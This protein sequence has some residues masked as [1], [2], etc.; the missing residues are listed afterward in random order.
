MI[1]LCLPRRRSRWFSHLFST[2]KS[3]ISLNHIKPSIKKSPL[4]Q[5]QAPSHTTTRLEHHN[6]TYLQLPSSYFLIP[7]HS[8]L[9]VPSIHSPSLAPCTSPKSIHR[10]H[11]GSRFTLPR[12]WGPCKPGHHPYTHFP[13]FLYSILSLSLSLI[14][15]YT[16][17]LGH[18]SP[19]PSACLYFTPVCFIPPSPPFISL[20]HTSHPYPFFFKCPLPYPF[21]QL[22]QSAYFSHSFTIS[23]IGHGHA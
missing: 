5:I 17:S 22:H 2:F 6:H 12:A 21:F 4:C 14:I 9:L 13:S 15:P 16:R 19:S 8:P 23:P 11:G 1:H 3:G 7:L 18:F 10:L 20:H